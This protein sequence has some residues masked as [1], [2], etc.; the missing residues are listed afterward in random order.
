MKKAQIAIFVIIGIMIISVVSLILY[1]QTSSLVPLRLRPVESFFLG[2]VNDRALEGATILGEQGGYIDM[3]N[4]EAGSSEYPFTSQLNFFGSILP[5]WSYI[6]GNGIYKQQVPS[7]S[8]LE[9]QLASYMSKNIN[10]CDFSNFEKEGYVIEKSEKVPAITTRISENEITT[11]A[12]W[13]LTISFGGISKR[14]ETH[15]TKVSSSLGKLY[16]LAKKIY[17]NEQSSLFLENY[18]LDVITLY[19]PTTKVE[20]SCAPK[21]WSE[22]QVILDLKN[23]LAANIASIKLKGNYYRLTKEEN[24]YFEQD[25]G[26]PVKNQVFLLYS[27]QFPANIKVWPS[28]DGIM[29][30]DPVGLQEGL[31]ILGFCYVPYHFV[32]TVE[33]PVLVQLYDEYSNIFQFP[34]LVVIDRNKPR[35]AVIAEQPETL[36]AELCKNK[37]EEVTVTT[38]D[39]SLKPTEASISFKC[40][41]TIC[42]IGE[43]KFQQDEATLTALFPQCVNGFIVA[44]KEGYAPAKLQVST[45][46]PAIVNVI[47]QPFYNVNLQLLKDS[48]P[49]SQNETAFVSFVSPDYGTS[50]YWPEQKSVKLVEGTYNVTAQFFRQGSITIG[51]EKTTKCT[52][53]PAAGIIGVLGFEREECF[54]IILPAQTLTSLPGGGGNAGLSVS[55]EDLK[56]SK[57]LSISIPQQKIPGS[58]SELQDVFNLIS[59]EK[60]KILFE[61]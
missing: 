48:M 27:A 4:F 7:L 17:D 25:L 58:V 28:K 35:G 11:A 54:D 47:M 53:V 10:S 3:P 8:M 36:E 34:M 15:N 30:A 38:Q 9:Q 52:K 13:P 2:C 33:Y 61:R 14:V 40:L 45:N 42:R 18:T 50:I 49:L 43:T 21:V 57:S 46:E 31:G 16:S 41:D 23:A 24:K 51:E 37:L 5:Y 26:T 39:S 19:V 20:I 29:R 12:D 1:L 44:N 56:F 59:T 32:Y 60:L 55:E 22:Q 6:S